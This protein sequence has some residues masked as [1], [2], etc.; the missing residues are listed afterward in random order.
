MLAV[1]DHFDVLAGQALLKVA[2]DVVGLNQTCF[3]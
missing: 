1:A 2:L 3:S